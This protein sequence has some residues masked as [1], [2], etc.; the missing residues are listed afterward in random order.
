MG[1]T[2]IV[3]G[4]AL[5]I[6]QG[7][8]YLRLF[9]ACFT[10]SLDLKA[11]SPAQSTGAT[12]RERLKKAIESPKWQHLLFIDEIHDYL[13]GDREGGMT[14]SNLIKPMLSRGEIPTIG[15]TTGRIPQEYRKRTPL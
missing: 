6:V 2:A 9:L 12:S 3:E 11:L 13:G 8:A 15:A 7:D 10:F 1:K 4:L 5:A 14:V